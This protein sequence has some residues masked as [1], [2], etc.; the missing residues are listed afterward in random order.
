M[1]QDEVLQSWGRPWDINATT[2]ADGW[3]SQWVYHDADYSNAA[4]VYFDNGYVDAV[5][6]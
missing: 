4:Y 6:N 5:Q 2:T 1:T 3:T